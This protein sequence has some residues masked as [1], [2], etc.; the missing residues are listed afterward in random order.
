MHVFERAGLGRA[1]F[2]FV[3]YE[4]KTYQACPGAPIQVGSSC[5]YCGEGISNVYWLEGADGRRFKVGCDC[6]GKTG[7]RGI[8]DPIKREANRI[9]TAQRHAREDARIE[10]AKAAMEDAA[11][12]DALA[13]E[14]HPK[15]R[16]NPRS[17]FFADKT[18]LDWA[19]W[20]LG[21]SGRSGSIK[22]AR[23][24]ERVAKEC[25]RT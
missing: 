10:A 4:R 1:P 25:G 14:P 2:R 6:V 3:G 13:A 11:I 21:H 20:M 5:D 17:D 23:V 18:L 7:D 16:T 19:T 22:V 15:R 8:V 9:K 24:I 12:S